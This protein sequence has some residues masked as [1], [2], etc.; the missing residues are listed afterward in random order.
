MS[1]RMALVEAGATVHVMKAFGDWRG[2]WGALVTYE[3]KTGW[4]TGSY[5]S[6]SGCDAFVGEFGDCVGKDGKPIDQVDY[7][8]RL[9]AFGRDYLEYSFMTQEEAEAMVIANAEWDL[10]SDEVLAFIKQNTRKGQ[11]GECAI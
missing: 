2:S 8:K 7:D 5:G 10:Q 4:V 9:Y 6:C 3:G 11:L 1:Y